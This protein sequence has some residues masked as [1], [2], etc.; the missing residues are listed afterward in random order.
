MDHRSADASDSTNKQSNSPQERP[1]MKFMGF[2]SPIAPNVHA[3]Q[4]WVRRT[5]YTIRRPVA[6]ALLFMISFLIT[7]G[8]CGPNRASTAESRTRKVQF[9][10]VERLMATLV[11][12]LTLAICRAGHSGGPTRVSRCDVGHVPSQRRGQV[13]KSARRT[14]APESDALSKQAEQHPR[15]PLETG[16]DGR[17]TR[18]PRSSRQP[19]PL[20]LASSSETGLA[21]VLSS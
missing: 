19:C 5:P 2:V 20:E 18:D 11:P 13:S 10:T 6:I 4:K 15:S 7:T 21:V 12:E 3:K 1:R 14:Y 8:A 9:L 16:S 17:Q